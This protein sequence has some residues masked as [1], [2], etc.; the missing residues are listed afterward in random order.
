MGQGGR[1]GVY[2]TETPFVGGRDVRTRGIQLMKSW[3]GMIH[4][5]DWRLER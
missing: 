5:R 1:S 4:S 3:Y 2:R